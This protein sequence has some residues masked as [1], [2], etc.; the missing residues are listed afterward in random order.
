MKPSD[1]VL[2]ATKGTALALHR[3]TG[4]RLWEA[5][6]K[7]KWGA[8]FVSLVADE[9][10]VF[11]YTRGELFCLDLFTGRLLWSD[12]LP[13][14]GYNLASLALP[15]TAQAPSSAEAAEL[16]RRAASASAASGGAHGG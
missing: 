4:Q 3:E 10:R 1:M 14:L 2:L 5:P 9:R 11:A 16:A 7:T 8:D 12:N 6:L 13:G 15:G